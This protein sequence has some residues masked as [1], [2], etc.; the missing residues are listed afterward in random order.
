MPPQGTGDYGWLVATELAEAKSI[1]DGDLVP[2]SGEGGIG[3]GISLP[4]LNEA[5]MMLLLLV[6]SLGLNLEASLS[7]ETR[8]Q[9]LPNQS[10]TIFGWLDKWTPTSPPT[11]WLQGSTQ[12]SPPSWITITCFTQG[13]PWI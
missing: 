11:I 4:S 8:S 1:K 2:E 10:F 3:P 12:W 5:T 7:V 9:L 13:Y 6:R